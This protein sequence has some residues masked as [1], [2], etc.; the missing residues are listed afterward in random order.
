MLFGG[1]DRSCCTYGTHRTFPT[2]TTRPTPAPDV[3]VIVLGGFPSAE[4]ELSSAWTR[5]RVIRNFERYHNDNSGKNLD[6]VT[7]IDEI[8]MTSLG[9]EGW[10]LFDVGETEADM[11][12]TTTLS[13]TSTTKKQQS[14]VPNESG[15]PYVQEELAA[16]DA[17]TLA[18]PT[19]RTAYDS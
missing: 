9:V 18:E 10:A 4:P 12:T 7:T 13:S 1:S 5:H 2:S 8:S 6:N 3:P 14:C 11:S 17:K 15:I 16:K 19:F